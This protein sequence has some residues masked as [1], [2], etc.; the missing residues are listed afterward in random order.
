MT[1]N[2]NINDSY[3]KNINDF[4]MLEPFIR[5]WNKDIY[6]SGMWIFRGAGDSEWGLEP[7]FV[8]WNKNNGWH[9]GDNFESFYN[10]HRSL[11][12]SHH[13][14]MKEHFLA[15]DPDN[16]YKNMMDRISFSQHHGMKTLLLDWSYNPLIALWFAI[17]QWT[18]SDKQNDIALWCLDRGD[19]TFS[20]ER[21]LKIETEPYR[22]DNI[23]FDLKFIEPSYELKKNNKH[24]QQQSGLHTYVDIFRLRTEEYVASKQQFRSINDEHL[25]DRRSLKFSETTKK[26]LNI[27]E[28]FTK[29]KITFHPT[30]SHEGTL[31]TSS[32]SESFKKLIISKDLIPDILKV[33]KYELGTTNF[34]PS[35]HGSAH[36]A[37]IKW[38]LIRHFPSVIEF[39]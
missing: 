24:I 2:E 28:L 38:I 1:Y 14:A 3:I 34:Y 35:H 22:D 31:L 18:T 21:S 13:S 36:Y 8:R 6:K 32:A 7:A 29:N 11:V 4:S 39:L 20:L 19:V 10:E 23:Y 9:N 5:A 25:K 17:E 30:G 27:D 26:L 37:E 15:V 16:S 12:Q 33:I